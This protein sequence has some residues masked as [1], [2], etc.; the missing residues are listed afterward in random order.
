MKKKNQHKKSNKDQSSRL[1]SIK[2]EKKEERNKKIK[3]QAARIL[4]IK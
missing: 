4:E 1:L 3:Y 2:K